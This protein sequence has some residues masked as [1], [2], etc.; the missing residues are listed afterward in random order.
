[1][2]ASGAAPTATADAPMAPGASSEVAHKV[3]YWVTR[4][5]QTA[6]LQLDALGGS[7]VDVSITLQGKE[8]LVEFRCD[9]P[10]ARRLLQEAMPQL[11]DMLRS[12]GLQL[13]GGF[14]GSSAQQKEGG[15][16]RDGQHREPERVGTVSVSAADAVR[17]GRAG[18]ASTHSLDVFV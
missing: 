6:E 15:A 14:V 8:A 18:A 16:R 2:L 3:H 13:A 7:A 1:V 10:E 4:G 11:R 9:L 17:T 12:E 5:V